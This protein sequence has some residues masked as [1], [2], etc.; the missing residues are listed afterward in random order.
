MIIFYRRF[1]YRK[2]F[3]IG[4]DWQIRVTPSPVVVAPAG[5]CRVVA[6]VFLAPGSGSPSPV[7]VAPAG[8]CRVVASVF[9]APGSGSPSPVEVA[10]AGL[11]RVVAS[12]FLAPGSGSPSPVEVAP[13]GICRVVLLLGPRQWFASVYSEVTPA[14]PVVLIFHLRFKQFRHCFGLVLASCEIVPAAPAPRS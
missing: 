9:S 12:V 14:G 6:S 3:K 11:C 13:A 4:I 8:L 1:W 2:T 5:L 7:E 10:P